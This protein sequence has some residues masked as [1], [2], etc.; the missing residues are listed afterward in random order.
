MA[1]LFIIEGD[2]VKP[3]VETLMVEPYKTIWERDKTPRKG[4]AL[5]EFRFIEFMTSKKRSNPYAG[6]EDEARFKR[7][8]LDIFDE[9][10]E[11]DTLVEQGMIKVAE[12]QKEA[13]PTYRY[14]LAALMAV[15]KLVIFFETFDLNERSEKG[16]LLYKPADITR[17][18]NDTDKVMQNLNNMK[19]K[20]EQELFEQTKTRGNK[21]INPF[22]V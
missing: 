5:K 11:I 22:E 4:V 10:W 16:A 17:A 15:E 21:Q 1:Y 19:E 3:N 9:E 12:F 7:L 2:V 20:V 6:Y 18:V 8:Q 14:Y 13:S